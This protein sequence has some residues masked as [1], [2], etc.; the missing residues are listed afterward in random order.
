MDQ[1]NFAWCLRA[2]NGNEVA[3]YNNHDEVSFAEGIV[4]YCRPNADWDFSVLTHREECDI[5]RMSE[6]VYLPHKG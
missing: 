3:D 2:L 1:I 5:A 6:A 4:R